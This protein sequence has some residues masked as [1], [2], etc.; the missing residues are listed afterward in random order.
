M[1]SVLAIFVVEADQAATNSTPWAWW[2]SAVLVPAVSAILIILAARYRLIVDKQVA[3][4]H[5][6]DVAREQLM[7]LYA[8]LTV[9]TK[10]AE[11]TKATLES[12]AR[13]HLKLTEGDRFHVLSHAG[14]LMKGTETSALLEDML[15]VNSHIRELIVN[16][17]GHLR[18]EDDIAPLVAFL[19]HQTEFQTAIRRA[20]NGQFAAVKSSYPDDL[21]PMIG[22]GYAQLRSDLGIAPIEGNFENDAAWH[23]ARAELKRLGRPITVPAK[24]SDAHRVSSTSW[25]FVVI[26]PHSTKAQTYR[27]TIEVA[28]ANSGTRAKISESVL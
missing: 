2:I 17:S 21:D 1:H 27:F 4:R 8:P 16:K 25:M 24:P 13:P 28:Q 5:R 14:D 20:R 26:C 12:H 10:H 22:A 19:Q 7:D 23:V 9:M 15:V 6:E 11:Q 18:P 3:D